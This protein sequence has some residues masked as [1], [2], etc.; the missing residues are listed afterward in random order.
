MAMNAA[1]AYSQFNQHSLHRS[2]SLSPS[3]TP[4]DNH[5]SNA[6]RPRN[7]L[8]DHFIKGE[9]RPTTN[10]YD[11]RCRYCVEKGEIGTIR[12][13]RG[14]KKFM[15]AH[16][17]KCINAPEALRTRFRGDSLRVSETSQ[18]NED[19]LETK[20]EADDPLT[21]K[22]KL[23]PV[24]EPEWHPSSSTSSPNGFLPSTPDAGKK[25]KEDKFQLDEAFVSKYQDRL[26]SFGFNGLGEIIY[27]RTYSRLAKDGTREQWWQT[28]RRVVNGTF[29]MQKRWVEQSNLGWDQEKAQ[30][31]AQKM[32]D[33]IF[34]MKF[35]PPG[36]G[37]WAMGSPLTEERGIYTALNNCGFVSTECMWARG[38]TPSKPFAFLMDASMLGVGVGFDTKGAT[39]ARERGI[40]VTGPN[41]ALSPNVYVIPDCRE[42]WVKSIELMIDCYFDASM[43]IQ[44]FKYHCIRPEG[45]PI[46][47]FGGQSCGPQPL[48]DLH[49]RIREVLNNNIGAPITVTTIVDI[50]NLIGKC[51]ASGNVRRSAEIAF[52]DPFDDEYIDLKNYEVNPH[53]CEYGWTSN[54]SVFA[55]IGMDYHNICKRVV[56]NGE[57]GFSWLTNAQNYGRMGDPMDKRDYRAQG[58]N[59]CLEQTL[60]SFEL[61][62]LVE[63]FPNNH[64]TI[65]DFLETLESAFL[66]AKTVTLGTTHWPESNRVMMRNRRIGTG[67]SGIAQFISKRGIEELRVWCDEGYNHIL[68]ID[69]RLCEWLCIPRSIK[70]TTVKPSGTVSLLAGATPGLHYPESRFCIRRVRLS[71][72]SEMVEPFREAGYKVEPDVVDPNTLVVEIPIDHGEGIRSLVDVSMW[73][74]LSLA[75]FMQRYWSDNQVSCTI[76]F[77]PETEGDHL[78]FA[79]N[80][81]QYQLK[82]VSFLPRIPIGAY[83]QMPYEAI[84]EL[85]YLQLTAR[86]TKPGPKS[87]SISHL[88][89]NPQGLTAPDLRNVEG[90]PTV[91][92]EIE[93]FCDWGPYMFDSACSNLG[94]PEE[95]STY[96]SNIMRF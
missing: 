81:F 55:N 30:R 75:A 34:S 5:V 37:L 35:L 42:G 8:W 32:Y 59:P 89:L 73:E 38:F 94:L 95:A 93:K 4:L 48:I 14:E 45:A 77:D 65:N 82:G 79:L 70:I 58:G 1:S 61:C 31:S 72:I 67:L 88:L 11:A 19:E 24:S 2:S 68:D 16:L 44:E 47:G 15:V 12:P 62:C 39:I 25:P 80:Y 51:V 96:P 90:D 6:G 69:K 50:M 28:V 52:G 60:E 33:R 78:R 17:K 64:T 26:P 9:K 87:P 66:Y 71:R 20:Q 40:L 53:R 41:P 86:I 36:R 21:K 63:V 91:D 13:V 29:S 56:T 49:C 27:R 83:S 85:K 43:S 10:K 18:K 46:K 76:T 57:P 23:A 74:Q 92:P 7:E 54:N 22:R 84:S 3:P